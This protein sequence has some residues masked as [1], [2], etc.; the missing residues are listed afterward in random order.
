MTTMKCKHR[1]GCATV[2]E[3][4]LLIGEVVLPNGGHTKTTQLYYMDWVCV[5]V[6]VYVCLLDK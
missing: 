1:A 2:G 5:C 6:C 3:E 4:I